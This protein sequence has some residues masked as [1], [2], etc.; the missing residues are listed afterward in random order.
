M[1][2]ET[3]NAWSTRPVARLC[4]LRAV[5]PR[6]RA[7]GG[8]DTPGHTTPRSRCTDVQKNVAARSLSS[9]IHSVSHRP[10]RRSGMNARI[11]TAVL[12]A[13]LAM[14]S[15]QPAWGAELISGVVIAV[16]QQAT[17]SVTGQVVEDRTN[18]PLPSVQVYIAGTRIGGLTDRDGRYRLDNVPVGE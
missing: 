15:P 1:F 3:P 16:Q 17:A 2:G 11:G 6:S 5:I 8:A 12:M 9:H 13:T 10:Q 18:R 14:Q 7:I 4:G